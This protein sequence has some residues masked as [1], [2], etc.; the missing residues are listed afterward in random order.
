MSAQILLVEDDHLNRFALKMLLEKNGYI[1]HEA[2]DGKQALALMES[3]TI[4]CVLMDI[5]L[6]VM[7]GVESTEIIRAHDGTLYNPNVPIIAITAYAMPGDREKFLKA[8]MNDYLAKPV[9][10]QEVEQAMQ[11]LLQT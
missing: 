7:N 6:P 1:V 4:D 11:N 5:Q 2:E 8:G 10:I 3:Q 9:S